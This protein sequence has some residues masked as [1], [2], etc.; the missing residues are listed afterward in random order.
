MLTL[1]ASPC[2]PPRSAPRPVRLSE[3]A[4]ARGQPGRPRDRTPPPQALLGSRPRVPGLAAQPHALEGAPRAEGS[5]GCP[6]R[7]LHPCRPHP[8]VPQTPLGDRPLGH[9]TGC[10]QPLLWASTRPRDRDQKPGGTSHLRGRRR[11]KCPE[12]HGQGWL[13]VQGVAEGAAR[14]AATAGPGDLRVSH[15]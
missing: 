2:P 13:R 5:N 10:R 3:E 4:P 6:A 8:K 1:G 9:G 11:T 15:H 7:S 14:P 12:A